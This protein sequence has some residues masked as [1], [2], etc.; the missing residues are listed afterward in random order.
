MP[1]R[2]VFELS[3]ST[4]TG[5]Y[6]IELVEG[7]EGGNALHV[8]KTSTT[9]G[10]NFYFHPKEV[11]PSATMAVFEADILLKN[12][13]SNS[14]IE[15]GFSRSSAGMGS[16]AT[17]VLLNPVGTNK[18]SAIT[19]TD[20]SNGASNQQGIATGATVGEW[21]TLR[22]EYCEG[23]LDTFMLRTYVNGKL[24]YTSKAVYSSSICS[25]DTPLY[26]A[27]EIGI[28]SFRLNS[29][30]ACDFYFDNAYL[31]QMNIET[32]EY[33]DD[34]NIED[35]QT[36]MDSDSS[37]MI[38][39]ASDMNGISDD[40]NYLAGYISELILGEDGEIFLGNVDLKSAK[41]IIFGRAG[42]S[43]EVQR[44]YELLEA[45]EKPEG[46]S[47]LRYLIYASNGKIV[48]AFDENVYTSR[49]PTYRMVRDFVKYYLQNIDYLLLDEGVV[50]KGVVDIRLVQEEHDKTLNE[51]KWE[52]VRSRLGDDDIYESLRNYYSEIFSDEI[53]SLIGSFYDPATG[54]FYASTSG[55]R[56]E[57]IYPIPEATSQVLSYISSSGALVSGSY[58]TVMPA[59]TR[60][61]IIYYL[62]SIQGEDG[63]FYVP[64]LKK[65]NIDSNRVGRDRS[66]CVTLFS[67]FRGKPT[68]DVGSTK[69]DGITADQYWQ[70]LVEAGLVTE[71]DKPIIYWADYRP[72]TTASLNRSVA[73]AVSH[74]VMASDVVSVAAT[75]QF[76][77]HVAFVK[78]LLAK[79]GY[80]SPYS[81]MSSTSSASSIIS[82][83]SKKLGGF[84][85]ETTT[86]TY[87]GRSYELKTGETLNEILINWMNGYIN[88]AGLFGKVTNNYDSNG[89]P[90]YDGFFGGWGYQNSN[91]FFKAIGRYSGQKIAYPAPREA[92]ESLLKG[93]NSD[94]PVTSNV[95]VLYNVWS[96]LGS[97]R[98]NVKSYYKGED[99]Q[100]ILD[101]IEET[102]FSKVVDEATG[103]LRTYAALGIDKALA[104]LA[105]F[106]KSD[107]GLGHNA[108]AGSSGWQGGLPVG[109]PADNLSDIDAISCINNGLTSSICS[110]LGLNSSSVPRNSEADLFL[111]LESLYAQPYVTKAPP[112]QE[113]PKSP[114]PEI[115]TFDQMPEWITLRT[116][117]NS[118]IEI[119][120][121]VGE[122][123]LH[124]D[125]ATGFTAFYYNGIN[126]KESDPTVTVIGFD[127][128]VDDVVKTGGIEI[129]PQMDGNSMFLPYLAITGTSDGAKITVV[130]HSS[131]KGAIASGIVVGKWASIEIRYFEKEKKYDFYVDGKFVISGSHLRYGTDYP[132]A[133]QINRVCV[134]MNSSNVAQFYYDNLYIYQLNEIK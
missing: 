112:K 25:G 87:S 100:E 115:E 24:I 94:E 92:A 9:S 76:Q 124:V 109:I 21:F 133:D 58:L 34:G 61:K 29:G 52:D 99:K 125:K 82:D 128:M 1:E 97:L 132:S 85:G 63:E 129:Y 57:G 86:I 26:K 131:G 105:A 114:P 48:F 65:A 126:K 15:I 122:S 54:L 79:D 64:Q 40:V 72:E 32:T 16:F 75:D 73:V 107:G 80:N 102:I 110:V 116:G 4:S 113:K 42:N 70:T 74:A 71:E 12:V 50:F 22:M 20:Y 8:N 41:E 89:N 88:E 31:E 28:L 83:W 7:R 108:T 51:E 11:N 60:Y 84:E 44:A 38:T 3:I 19:Y 36:L 62:K 118:T 67:R 66:A 30:L 55:K 23:D 6:G 37:I 77:S 45:M 78:W 134:A 53:L 90:V 2:S 95:L 101:L 10:G 17:L 33:E 127:L 117:E 18:G 5:T 39:S 121:M 111:F 46:I 47:T 14:Q 91:G 27:E 98:S 96:S 81:A 103:E 13:V 130:D 43:A 120:E 59:V 68:Y 35:G 106:R 119:D 49:Q 69:G 93:I 104:K 56:A 123:V